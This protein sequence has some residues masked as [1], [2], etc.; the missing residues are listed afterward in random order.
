MGKLYIITIICY[1]KNYI[2]F[3]CVAVWGKWVCSFLTFWDFGAFPH[4]ST[5]STIQNK[6]NQQIFKVP[7]K[8]ENENDNFKLIHKKEKN[9]VAKQV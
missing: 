7:I 5:I 4:F 8:K 6:Q 3:I 1:Y 2:Y 9:Q